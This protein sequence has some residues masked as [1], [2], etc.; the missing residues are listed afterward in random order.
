MNL[1]NKK[2]IDFGFVYVFQSSCNI[3]NINIELASK[4][5]MLDFNFRL[6]GSEEKELLFSKHSC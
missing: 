4:V 3:C 5:Y 1:Q 6:R 2:E